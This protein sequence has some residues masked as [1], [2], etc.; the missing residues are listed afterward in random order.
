MELKGD[1]TSRDHARGTEVNVT[2]M[3][4]QSNAMQQQQQQSQAVIL[5]LSQ[6]GSA[7]GN[8]QVAQAR[9]TS[10]VIG[11]TGPVGTNQTAN[12]VNVM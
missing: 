12:P 2:Q 1:R 5:A 10:N 4:N 7:L 8:I 11:N 9:Q 6:I 3:V